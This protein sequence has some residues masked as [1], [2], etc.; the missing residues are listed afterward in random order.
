[1]GGESSLSPP[2]QGVTIHRGGIIELPKRGQRFLTLEHV[3]IVVINTFWR[4][5]MGGES[6][7]APPRIA[8]R[9]RLFNKG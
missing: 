6:S 9:G 3:R 1:M 5:R 2:L 7:F 8:V 4:D